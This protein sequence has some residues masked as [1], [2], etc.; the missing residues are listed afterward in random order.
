MIELTVRQAQLYELILAKKT[1]TEIIEATGVTRQRLAII[2]QQLITKGVIKERFTLPQAAVTEQDYPWVPA[3]HVEKVG[4]TL[5]DMQLRLAYA[6]D[7]QRKGDQTVPPI[8]TVRWNNWAVQGVPILNRNGTSGRSSAH[9]VP[10]LR[11]VTVDH[12]GTDS[13]VVFR[14]SVREPWAETD[15]LRA[16]ASFLGN[17]SALTRDLTLVIACAIGVDPVPD[18]KD[19]ETDQ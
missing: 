9:L 13:G 14:A 6:I 16:L 18:L 17:S 5:P 7:N 1:P 15:T 4:I 12:L 10:D 11:V 3:P 19:K 8:R 2:R